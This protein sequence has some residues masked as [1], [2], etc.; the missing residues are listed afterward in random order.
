MDCSRVILDY[1]VLSSRSKHLYYFNQHKCKGII[2]M[3][4]YSGRTG[5]KRW[6]YIHEDPILMCIFLGG[7]VAIIALTI[8]FV[9]WRY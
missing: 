3:K 7:P 4:E 2:T 1:P 5:I 8:L 6:L 9:L